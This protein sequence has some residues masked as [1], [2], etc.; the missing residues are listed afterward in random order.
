MRAHEIEQPEAIFEDRVMVVEVYKSYVGERS[1]Y[2][3][4]R[5][6]W[7]ANA[8]RAKNVDYVLAVRRGDPWGVRAN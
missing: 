2:D 3:A 4:T 7:K 6:A 8:Y 1:L 5:Y